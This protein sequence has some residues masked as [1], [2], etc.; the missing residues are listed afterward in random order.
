MNQSVIVWGPPGCGKTSN[1]SQLMRHFG[2]GKVLEFDGDGRFRVERHHLV[3]HLILCVDTTQLPGAMLGLK[4][5]AFA[6]VV[7]DAAMRATKGGAQ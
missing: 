3:D 2:L 7:F 5:H 6:D 4:C 1:Q